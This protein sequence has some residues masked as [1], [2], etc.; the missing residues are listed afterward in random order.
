MS[1]NQSRPDLPR[2]GVV[3]DIG[4]RVRL[5]ARLMADARVSLWLKILPVGSVVYLFFPDLLIGPIDDA[6]LLWLA[7]TLFVELAPQ[8]IVAEHLRALQGLPPAQS[9][10][11]VVD[12]TFSDPPSPEEN[13][14]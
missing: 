3:Q 14:Q 5:V 11:P 1:D 12:A 8:E 13:P 9:S 7:T 6:L 10:G 2:G 4:L